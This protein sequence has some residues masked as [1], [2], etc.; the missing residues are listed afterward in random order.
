MTS[1]RSTKDIIAVAFAFA[2]LLCSSAQASNLLGFDRDSA[3]R[4]AV[5][6]PVG[7]FDQVSAWLLGAWTD[8]TSVF[9][10]ESTT[11]PITTTSCDAGWGLDPEGCPR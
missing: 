6:R 3:P 11:P 4:T 5:E 8:L 2:L 1:K 7:L 9:A 10:E